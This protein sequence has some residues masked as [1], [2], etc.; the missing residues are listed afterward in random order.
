MKW[1]LN[2]KQKETNM[3]LNTLKVRAYDLLAQNEVL[4]NELQKVNAAIA[5]T[6]QKC[7]EL[8]CICKKEKAEKIEKVEPKEEK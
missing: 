8:P 4:R 1:E 5:N 6:C 2:P 3:N 7:N